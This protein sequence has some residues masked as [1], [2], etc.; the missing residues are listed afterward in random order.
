[1]EYYYAKKNH[2]YRHLPPWRAGCAEFKEKPMEFVFP[3]S[4][5]KIYVPI[6]ADEKRGK[7][8][9]RI[10]HRRDDVTLY[11]HLDEEYLG[12]TKHI[13]ELG[14]QPSAGKHLV[15]VIDDE[16]NV[17]EKNIEVLGGS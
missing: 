15:T 11:W 8:V 14:M 9:F 3:T 17:L 1:M 12:V 7:V 6:E 10:A 2:T 13:H 4:G 16:G 5:S